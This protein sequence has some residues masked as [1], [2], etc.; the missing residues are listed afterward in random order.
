MSGSGAPGRAPLLRLR[1]VGRSFGSFGGSGGSGDTVQALRDVSFDVYEG[2]FVAIVGPS[3]AGKST[4]LNVLGLLDEPDAGEYVVDGVDVCSLSERQRDALRSRAIG[5]VFQ[6]S[7]IM[8]DATAAENAA[9][10]LRVQSVSLARRRVEVALALERLGLLSRAGALGRNLSGGER[11]RV[12]IARAI[13]TSPRLILADEPTGALDSANSRRLLDYLRSLNEAGTTIVMITHD[14]RVAAQAGRRFRLSDGRLTDAE[15]VADDPFRLRPDAGPDGPPPEARAGRLRRGVRTVVDETLEAVSHHANAP[16]RALLLLL[17]FLLGTA[18][19]VAS[20]GI[21]QSA[22]A[23]VSQRITTAG[24]DEITV[25]PTGSTLEDIDRDLSRIRLLDGVEEAGFSAAITSGDATV[26]ALAQSPRLG[27]DR[28]TGNVVIADAAYLDAQGIEVSPAHAAALLDNDWAGPVA[29]LGADAAARLGVVGSGSTQRIWI[30]DVAVDIVGVVSASGR[31]SGVAG[32]VI[33]SAAL[34]DTVHHGAPQLLVRTRVGSPAPV[35]EA[36][37]LSLDPGN[38]AAVRVSTVAD[39]RRLRTGVGED[40]ATLI[41]VSSVV[42]L[43]LASLSAATA[44]YLSVRS[45]A[46]E[47]ALRRAIGS[48]RSAIWRMFTLEGAVIGAAGGI[49]GGAVGILTLLVT[50]AIQG[51]VPVLDPTL[52]AVGLLLGTVTGVVSA[53]YPALAAARA[54]PAEAIRG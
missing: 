50:A 52:P 24:L 2:E 34:Y 7:H 30:D 10:G 36:I 35:A 23:Q 27:Q 11:Q 31:D 51:W 41:G 40:L 46:P 18:G 14:E 37:P 43:A 39:L 5:F 45:R 4:L 8:G 48:S 12:A 6:A 29:I 42:L 26:T 25:E 3:G 17:A 33:A 9:L 49:A 20:L 38:P 13:A 16:V 47:I 53:T 1:G 22:A 32:G 21:S 15:P 54:N 44:M 19:L 28:F